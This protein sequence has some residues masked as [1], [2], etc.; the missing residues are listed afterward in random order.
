MCN[1]TRTMHIDDDKVHARIIY[2]VIIYNGEKKLFVVCAVKLTTKIKIKKYRLF[3]RTKPQ[4]LFRAF[5]QRTY[6]SRKFTK[7]IT[8]IVPICLDVAL[9]TYNKQ[10]V[11]EDF[12]AE[13]EY[14]RVVRRVSTNRL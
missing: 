13:W 10:V 5:L 7:S 8:N 12:M 4:T 9:R 3:V 11:Y 1:V 6:F 14:G 2:E